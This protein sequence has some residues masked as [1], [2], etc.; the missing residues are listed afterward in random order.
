MPYNM[1]IVY[2]LTINYCFVTLPYVYRGILCYRYAA[3]LCSSW[4]TLSRNRCFVRRCSN[5]A[6]YVCL[7]HKLRWW[8][9]R[10]H[11]VTWPGSRRRPEM[12]SFTT[13]LTLPTMLLLLASASAGWQPVHCSMKCTRLARSY[14]ALFCFGFES[15]ITDMSY[16]SNLLITD[17]VFIAQTDGFSD[18]RLRLSLV[19]T[20]VLS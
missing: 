4:M 17:T 18:K 8:R 3:Q 15:K 11:D 10:H 7:C 20:H 16:P 6:S 9:D 12:A 5:V 1:E 13:S 19:F 2:I 14:T